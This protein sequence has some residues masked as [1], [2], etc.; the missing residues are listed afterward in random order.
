M[1]K[2]LFIMI[3]LTSFLTM[4]AQNTSY[5]YIRTRDF[6]NETGTEGVNAF[7]YFDGIGRKYQDVRQGAST[8]GKD[9]A[10]AR[11]YDGMG[12]ETNVFLPVQGYTTGL[13]LTIQ[14][15]QT[16]L[17]RLYADS[18]AY[19]HTTY[20]QGM[21]NRV[22]SV[23][24]P[25]AAWHTAGKAVKTEYLSNS[26]TNDS[27]ICYK[28]SI[29]NDRLRKKGNYADGQLRVIKTTD[30]D[31]NI[32]LTFL[33]SN[34]RVVLI[35]SFNPAASNPYNSQVNSTYY[36]CD[37]HGNLCWVLPPDSS[38]S[39]KYD[40]FYDANNNSISRC[41]YLYRYDN[42]QRRIESHWPECE[43]M[44]TI[45]DKSSRPVL[46]Q[47]G[48]LRNEGKWSYTYYT[49]FGEIAETGN[50]ILSSE[51]TVDQ[52]RSVIGKL[53]AIVSYTYGQG[54]TLNT[55]P[56]S[57]KE[58]L[59]TNYYDTYDFLNGADFPDDPLFTTGIYNAKGQLTGSR[60]AILGGSGNIY[61]VFH[62]DDKG[63]LSRTLSTNHL[64][65]H[66]IT[67]TTY[68]FKGLP[69]TVETIH[70]SGNTL[71]PSITE[72]YTYR[73]DNWDRL[74]QTNHNLNGRSVTLYEQTYDALE[75][76]ASQSNCNGRQTTSYSYN[77]RGWLSEI[78]H[79]YFHQSLHY[80]D[81][82]NIPHF[83]GNLS[84]ML[85]QSA[86][87]SVS[88]G[89]KY[90]YNNLSQ[91]TDAIYGEGATLSSNVDRF[92]ERIPRYT[93][94]GNILSLQRYGQI[95]ETEYGLID[96]LSMRSY[97]SQLLS[98]EDEA[99]DSAYNGGFEFKDGY[100]FEIGWEE[101]E[102]FYDDNGNLIKDLNKK[103][104]NIAYNTLNLPRR[105]EF[106]NGNSISYLYCADGT[107]L[108]CTHVIDGDTLTTD[109][110]GSVL[111]ENDVP[112]TLLT[113]TGY[114]SLNDNK[115]HYF[116][117][118][119]QGNNRVVTDEDST[120]EETNDYY[121]FGGLM[122]S[123]NSVQ[124][125][126]YNG[127]E[128]DR[129]SGLDWYDYGSRMY[130]ATLGRWYSIDPMAEKHYAS[131]P[132]SYCG[133][134]PVMRIDP[135][136][137]DWIKDRFDYYLWDENSVNRET[138]REGWDYVGTE[139]PDDVGRYR[140][141]EEIDG[142]LYHKNTINPFASFINWA[143][144]E[145]LM[146]EKKAYDPAGDHMMQQGIETGAEFAVGEIGGKVGAKI[147]SKIFKAKGTNV[148]YQ[149]VDANHT[150]RYI[151][152]TE[153]EP[154][155][156]FT[157]HLNSNTIR[158]TLKYDVIKGYTKLTREQARYWEQTFINKYGLGKNGGQLYNKI[159]SISPDFWKELGIK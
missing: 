61:S 17:L 150:V 117:Q 3:F 54:Y 145:D 76:L 109:Y 62:Y 139:L 97:N 4:E 137:K 50:C 66:D 45:Y 71:L 70:T 103:I 127:K 88:R 53:Y 121:P 74:L 131:C 51:M 126:K 140:I 1:K 49:P 147:F 29:S 98:V 112:R 81:G 72:K 36:V 113:E 37:A 125:Y 11:Q 24:G 2:V 92:T 39:L 155:V 47:D 84:S 118:D 119:H 124:P 136:G 73:Y 114:I 69:L 27:L 67:N 16:G 108:R 68:T 15:V 158:S 110:C 142:N 128:L 122:A 115:Y 28:F 111:Y 65:G 7:A 14:D 157:E 99:V 77:L 48:N 100:T 129:K 86:N 107:K 46:F 31:G 94:H 156:R 19:T 138:T 25:G 120:I 116:I 30:E 153:R 82:P 38:I 8:D 83:N 41:S 32:T 96:D 93:M 148:V 26:T 78:D 141:L 20:Q 18:M 146:V 59:T 87:D 90:T 60:K 104:S 144:G 130:D 135:N 123:S 91:L 10:V 13:P 143:Y 133:S 57:Q 52:L 105:I 58:I 149:G 134:N 55:L 33:D 22:S 12:R 89:Y 159:N 101:D 151:G 80:T 75:R 63:Q 85:W 132:Y 43:V 5:N 34:E 35:R 6:C 102:Y 9:L 95:S 106:E 152:I 23:T 79:P 56:I 40:G 64:G 42:C 154:I 21:A 44:Y